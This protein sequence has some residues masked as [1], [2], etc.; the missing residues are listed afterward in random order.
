MEMSVVLS[1]LLLQAM[2][3]D[4]YPC[5]KMRAYGCH[6][7]GIVPGIRPA[8][9]HCR[10][11]GSLGVDRFSRAGFDGILFSELSDPPLTTIR[12]PVKTI[13][14]EA[15]RL[16]RSRMQGESGA[17][18]RSEIAPSLIVRGSSQPETSC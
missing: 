5:E 11:S 17:A 14:A 9:G 10:R 3:I 12:Q 13:A 18:R 8:P 15:D 6:R 4:D 16:L 7:A 2:R 1:V